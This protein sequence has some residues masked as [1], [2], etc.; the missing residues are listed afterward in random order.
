MTSP[1]LLTSPIRLRVDHGAVVR[2][3]KIQYLCS[4]HHHVAYRD[5][6]IANIL[7]IASAVVHQICT[8]A[9][10][11]RLAP[12][13]V[14]HTPPIPLLQP[15]LHDHARQLA[16]FAHARAVTQQEAAAE[17]R[18]TYELVAL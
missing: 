16:P 15:V 11:H 18:G 1:Q 10:P 4:S 2:V 14:P 3:T 17:A 13:S 7:Q 12:P 9:D 6:L 5:A 8:F